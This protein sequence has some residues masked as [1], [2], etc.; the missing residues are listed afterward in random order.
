MSSGTQPVLGQTLE[1]ALGSKAQ[2]EQHGV[3]NCRRWDRLEEGAE[4]GKSLEPRMPPRPPPQQG[5][6]L[7]L[8]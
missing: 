4:G 5:W 6:L 3:S 8:E 1:G 2:D 7:I